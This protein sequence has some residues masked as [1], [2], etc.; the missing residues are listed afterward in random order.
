MRRSS[1]AIVILTAA[2]AACDDTPESEPAGAGGGGAYAGPPIPW[3]YEPFPQ[4][5]ETADNPS[6]PEKN[7][8]GNLLFYAAAIAIID[9]NLG[10]VAWAALAA[11]TLVALFAILR[12]QAQT[13]L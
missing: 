6:T 13:S 7:K 8:L 4:P 10:A 11:A 2:I 5:I 3:A 1:A 12:P 9:L